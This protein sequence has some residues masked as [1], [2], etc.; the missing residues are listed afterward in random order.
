M[1][2]RFGKYLIEANS[3]GIDEIGLS[4]IRNVFVSN[5]VYNK[6]T[7]GKYH[8]HHTDIRRLFV[9]TPAYSRCQS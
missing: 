3:G 4:E 8:S 5:Q 9:G 2:Q 7:N 6:R 1:Q